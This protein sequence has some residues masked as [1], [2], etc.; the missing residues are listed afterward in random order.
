MCKFC[1]AN[2]LQ[3]NRR[4]SVFPIVFFHCITGFQITAQQ[5]TPQ[6]IAGTQVLN[7]QAIEPNRLAT[8]RDGFSR[9]HQGKAKSCLDP[10]TLPFEPDIGFGLWFGS[11]RCKTD[12]VFFPLL[13]SGAR[14]A[15]PITSPLGSRVRYCKFNVTANCRASTEEMIIHPLFNPHTSE[16]FSL[17]SQMMF[18]PSAPGILAKLGLAGFICF[19]YY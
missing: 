7:R 9:C 14:S 19:V 13:A 5:Y 1:I 16:T 8:H 17:T 15:V 4:A 18:S 3:S 2:G 6:G 10:K 11:G 12:F